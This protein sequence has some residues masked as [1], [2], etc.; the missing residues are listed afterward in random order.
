MQDQRTARAT[1]A[2][3]KPFLSEGNIRAGEFEVLANDT[4]CLLLKWPKAIPLS[5][6]GHKL[7]FP[8]HHVATTLPQSA[9]RSR[10]HGQSPSHIAKEPAGGVAKCLRYLWETVRRIASSSET[11]TDNPN[12]PCAR[13]ISGT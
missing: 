5:A 11:D 4:A 13:P 10:P 12:S 1:T 2:V 7:E 9:A 6:V 8:P 3:K